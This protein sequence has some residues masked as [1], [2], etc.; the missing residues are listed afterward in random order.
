MT[1]D[2]TAPTARDSRVPLIVFAAPLALGLTACL[3]SGWWWFND[4]DAVLCGAWRT[5]HGVSAYAHGAGCPGGRPTDYMYLPQL[6]RAL[7]PIARGSDITGLRLVFGAGSLAVSAGLIHVLFLRPMAGA[8]QGLRAPML[9][10][11]GG[12]AVASANVAF[13]CH[14]LV[15]AAALLRRRAAWP[16]IG[17][18]VA[19]STVKPIY[20][21]YLLI[22]AFEPTPLSVRAGRIA[23]GVGAACAVG[24]VVAA[25]GGPDLAAWRAALNQVVLGEQ[26]GFSFLSWL[27]AIGVKPGDRATQ[28]AYVGYAAVV[29]LAG[30]I[31]VEARRLSPR[32]RTLLAIG[33]AQL[34]NPRLMIYDVLMLAPLAIG[35]EA[36]PARWRVAFRGAVIAIGVLACAVPFI[37]VPALT[38]IPPGLLTLLLLAAGLLAAR[39]LWR[40]RGQAGAGAARNGRRTPS[41]RAT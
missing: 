9:A 31:I 7:A 20:L 14:G 35:F 23:A 4:L 16:L 34:L 25:T 15:L 17:A 2:Q 10:M 32:A 37:G 33:V 24:I 27:G 40:G 41:A 21:T 28:L 38:S 18:I 19:V 39:D 30:L 6:A 22:F 29:S 36:V 3:V 13:V 1:L 5:A 26:T 8:P 12:R 11:I